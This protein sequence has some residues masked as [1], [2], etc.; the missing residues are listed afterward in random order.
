MNDFQ[1]SGLSGQS[2]VQEAQSYNPQTPGATLIQSASEGDLQ[3]TQSNQDVLGVDSALSQ[4]N[5]VSQVQVGLDSNASGE[6]GGGTSISPSG[7]SVSPW[8]II[9]LGVFVVL[10]GISF[11][12]SQRN[13][14]N[15][16]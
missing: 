14:M 5:A 6:L 1:Q 11:I 16:T 13:D 15:R 4:S 9:G 2:A 10:S 3:T 8:L 12:W 7:F